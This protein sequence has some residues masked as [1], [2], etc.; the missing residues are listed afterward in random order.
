MYFEG[1]RRVTVV[2]GDA[3]MLYACFDVVKMMIWWISWR[4][5]WCFGACVELVGSSTIKRE[6]FD[7]DVAF[8]S[9]G[10]RVRLRFGL[11]LL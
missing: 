4:L 11:V 6:G 8:Q 10:I 1:E 7:I 9:S 2:G 5:K 3:M